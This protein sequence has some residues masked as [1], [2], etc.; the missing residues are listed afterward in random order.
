MLFLPVEYK[1][2]LYVDG[3]IV[4]NYP[5]DNP[6]IERKKTIGIIRREYS[7]NPN[8]E[9][10]IHDNTQFTHFLFG[11]VIAGFSSPISAGCEY[12]LR[13]NT[14]FDAWVSTLVS[15][16]ARKSLYNDGKFSD[17]EISGVNQ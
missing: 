15:S 14:S 5:I 6:T 2:E 9:E 7:E 17:P 13:Q 8:I 10:L 11:K 3:G 4:N 16:E 1:G 12:R